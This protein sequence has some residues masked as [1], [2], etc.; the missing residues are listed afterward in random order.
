MIF[1]KPRFSASV[2]PRLHER[3]RID[4]ATVELL[5]ALL[6]GPHVDGTDLFPGEAVEHRDRR[7]VRALMEL[8][9]DA[10][11]REL[12]RRVDGRL[13]AHVDAL[14]VERVDQARIDE[15]RVAWRERLRRGH[16]DPDVH[17]FPSEQAFRLGDVPVE[18]GL[19]HRGG[20]KARARP[21]LRP[22]QA[23]CAAM[24]VR[25]AAFDAAPMA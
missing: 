14:V 12:D 4:L 5:V 16:H 10:L 24:I 1:L 19:R 6:G 7:V 3:C 8:D 23:V 15:A 11:A 13:G 21:G 20:V 22:P 9:A 18:G 17:S 25:N 2:D